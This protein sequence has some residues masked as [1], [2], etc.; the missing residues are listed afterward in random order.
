MISFTFIPIYLSIY[1]PCGPWQLFQFLNLYTVGRT[2]WTGDQP[3]SRPLP[4]HRATQTQDESTQTS[5]PRVGFEPM[6]SVFVRGKTVHAL[7]RVATV[8]GT[9][10]PQ[11]PKKQFE[12]LKKLIFGLIWCFN[13]I[14]PSTHASRKYSL[15]PKF[16][17][18]NVP[19][20]QFPHGRYKSQHAVVTE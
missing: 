17:D 6:I 16:L 10:I 13:I 9:F 20:S 15:P 7:D 19:N 14:I 8:I 4:T 12:Y 18:Q 2:P 5:M 11:D 1:S 3:V